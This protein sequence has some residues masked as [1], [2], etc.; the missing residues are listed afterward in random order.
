MFVFW[1]IYPVSL[2]KTTFT[3]TR[4]ASDI[5]VSCL[6][7]SQTVIV[8]FFDNTDNAPVFNPLLYNVNFTE[9]TGLTPYSCA[10]V[11]SILARS[12][13]HHPPPC[14]QPIPLQART[15]QGYRPRF[16]HQL[17]LCLL[18]PQRR[19]FSFLC[20]WSLWKRLRSSESSLLRCS[21]LHHL[22]WCPLQWRRTDRQYVLFSLL[23]FLTF[24]SE[25]QRQDRH[26]RD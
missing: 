8:T 7:G 22:R 2:N 26:Q 19:H 10:Y 4:Y 24:P 6:T 11:F 20:R 15:G 14:R 18:P 21:F 23:S 5:S 25:Q 16:R 1:L 12:R 9:F 13:L 3:L 17:W